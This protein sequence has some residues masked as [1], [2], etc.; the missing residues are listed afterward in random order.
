MGTRPQSELSLDEQ[1]SEIRAH[2][3]ADGT[4][5]TELNGRPIL[6][7]GGVHLNLEKDAMPSVTLTIILK[8]W[9]F[10]KD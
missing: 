6:T 9:E 8:D 10:T 1:M 2:R 4:L 3:K 5:E 7:I